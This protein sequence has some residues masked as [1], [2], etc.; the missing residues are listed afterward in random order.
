MVKGR[1]QERLVG[2]AGKRLFTPKNMSSGDLTGSNI[3]EIHKMH[4]LV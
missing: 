3:N 2:L 1:L 4:K